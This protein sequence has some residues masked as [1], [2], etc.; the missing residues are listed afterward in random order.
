MT[1]KTANGAITYKAV[2]FWLPLLVALVSLGLTCG[3]ALTRLGNVELRVLA[4]E[5]K[6]ETMTTT[7]T[8][9]KVQLA[10][11]QRDILYIREQI[12]KQ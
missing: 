12:D 7:F 9:I 5:S 8:E 3:V 2:A 11:I 6:I 4:Q 1:S 10:G